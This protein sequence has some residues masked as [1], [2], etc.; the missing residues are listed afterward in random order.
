MEIK[1]S[2]KNYSAYDQLTKYAKDLSEVYKSVKERSKALEIA[3]QQLF[4]YA[5]DLNNN[6]L[7]LKSA[8][9]DLQ[10]AYLDTIHRLVL[11]AE[12][13]DEDTGEH[14]IRIGHY[15]ALIARKLGLSSNEVKNILYAAPMHDV[16]KIGIPDSILMK[17]SKLTD[18]EFHF[19]KT[20]T[21]IGAKILEDSRAEILQLA[22]Q[23]AISHHERWNGKGYPRGL[24]GVDIPIVGRIVG[25]AD[26]FDALTSRRP[27]KEPYPVDLVCDIIKK[28]G[29]HHFEPELSDLLLENIDEFLNIKEEVDSS[30]NVPLP[31]FVKSERDCNEMISEVS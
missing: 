25:V 21:I 23:I 12:Y 30:E 9:K 7:M 17:P 24:S 16:G 22:E 3:N 13:R 2:S 29:G 27:Y 20:H 6:I 8:H 4:K 31:D 5:E 15:S 10:D 19:M 1:D 18:D 14:I 26:V 28:E 11:A